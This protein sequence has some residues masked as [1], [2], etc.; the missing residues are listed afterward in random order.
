MSILK[1]VTG[2]AA[3]ALGDGGKKDDTEGKAAAATGGTVTVKA[4]L[5]RQKIDGAADYEGHLMVSVT[6]SDRGFKR[7][8]ICTVLVLD[9][10]GSMSGEKLAA[11]KD[12]ASKLARNLSDQDE[13][14]IVAYAS[15][16]ETVLERTGA[17]NRETVLAAIARL[18]ATT[19]T[20]MSGGFAAGL[21]QVNEKFKG[22]KRVMLLTDGLANE[23]VSDR[24]GLLGVVK[25]R[26]SSCTVS[27]FG[28]GTDCDQELLADMAKAGGGNYYFIGG[29]DI[30]SVFAR[31]LGGML[32][33]VAQNLEV[34]IRPNRGGEVLEVLNDFTVEDK[35]GEASINAEDLYAGET[36]HVLVRLRV[37]KPD[38]RPKA[39]PFSVAHVAVS[40]DDA[41]SKGHERRELNPKVTFV[42]AK[43]ADAEPLLEV[44]EQVALVQAANAQLEAVKAAERG[45][46]DGAQGALRCAV[47]SFSLLADRGSESAR[48]LVGTMCASAKGFHEGTYTH[49]YGSTVSNAA[50][51]ATKYRKGGGEGAE[52]LSSVVGSKGVDDMEAAFR[53]ADGDG[54]AD[55]NVVAGSTTAPTTPTVWVNGDQSSGGHVLPPHIFPGPGDPLQPPIGWPVDPNDP[56]PIWPGGPHAPVQ[57]AEPCSGKA[58]CPCWACVIKR[59]RVRPR[60]GPGQR[61]G[62]MP[63][64]PKGGRQPA[65]APA[66][67]DAGDGKHK[68]KFAKRS[69]R[70]K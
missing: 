65:K 2:L 48:G 8:P 36:K 59:M 64:A 54:Q 51:N 18:Q 13:V 22:V 7:T 66:E 60:R 29:K 58:D 35:G 33:C 40:W 12:T 37:A 26:A 3:L 21:K 23:G 61:P 34:R 39:R 53:D 6:G 31:E 17:G 70:W 15:H 55:P 45:D 9:T 63:N 57:P 4:T 38:G 44:A 10:S 14:A 5:D 20:N 62:P 1:A 47:R 30:G 69:K 68:S 67:P 43:D 50:L 56:N 27:T 24:A 11:L 19:C 52:F 25:D 42:K 46:W 49:S 16:V 41:R 32:S 28:F